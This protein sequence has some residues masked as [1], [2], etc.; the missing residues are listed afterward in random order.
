[1]AF[2]GDDK[3]IAAHRIISEVEKD[4]IFKLWADTAEQ[5][6]HA[7]FERGPPDLADTKKAYVGLCKKDL[8]KEAAA[9]ENAVAN[10]SWAAERMSGTGYGSVRTT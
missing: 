8:R 7:G 3:T 1:M 5:K 6:T 4:L 9:L 10:K 2:D